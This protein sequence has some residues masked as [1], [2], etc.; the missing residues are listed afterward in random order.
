MNRTSSL[1]APCLWCYLLAY[2]LASAG[3]SEGQ[4]PEDIGGPRITCF[5]IDLQEDEPVA[6]PDVTALSPGE[7][8]STVFDFRLATL[9]KP[10]IAEMPEAAL[11]RNGLVCSVSRDQGGKY[12]VSARLCVEGEIFERRRVRNHLEHGDVD[13]L[14][15]PN[16]DKPRFVLCFFYSE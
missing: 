11:P 7:G 6:G 14:L 9:D 3:C 2:A 10:R 13:L 5:G 4:G 16:E 15:L 8:R 12:Y 1:S